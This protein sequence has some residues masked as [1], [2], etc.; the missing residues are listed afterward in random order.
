[1]KFI[2][3]IYSIL[4]ALMM[5][6]YKYKNAKGPRKHIEKRKSRREIK[7]ENMFI[8]RSADNVPQNC[9]I[10]TI[11]PFCSSLSIS[12]STLPSS[13]RSL[14]H[15]ELKHCQSYDGCNEKKAMTTKVG[16][17][18]QWVKLGNSI[19]KGLL[20]KMAGTVGRVQ[21]LV[22]ED[23]EIE[24]QAEADWVRGGLSSVWATSVAF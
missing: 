19:I 15:P 13:M 12:P 11:H 17:L 1:M 18:R 4:I 24:S 7:R 20:G 6:G 2:Q 3:T 5:R 22:A 8:V 23:R 14:Y 16:L 9:S 21:G 10:R